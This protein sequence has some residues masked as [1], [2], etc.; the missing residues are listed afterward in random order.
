MKN[1]AIRICIIAM[2]AYL[3]LGVAFFFI[4]GD[5]LHATVGSTDTVSAK[6]SLGE[7]L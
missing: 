5:S 3:L 7:K 2:A 1:K 6:A 4:A